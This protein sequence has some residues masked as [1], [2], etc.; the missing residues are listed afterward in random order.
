MQE[1]LYRTF[2]E[3]ES[4][5]WW[6]VARREIILSL[7]R[8]WL[9]PRANILDIGCGTGAFL[10]AAR[11]HFQV[12]GLDISPQA[13]A[14]C[15]ER[16]LAGVFEG[17]ASDLSGVAGQTFDG[18]LMLDVIEH[19]EDDFS[20][21]RN[22]RAMLA[23][24]GRI[25]ITVPAFM[26]FWSAHDEINQHKR[27]YTAT[28]LRNLLRDTGFHLEKLSYFNSFLFPVAVAVR[29]WQW[30]WGITASEYDYR[31]GPVN[32]LLRTVFSSEKKWLRK[33]NFPAG[34][35]LLAVAGKTPPPAARP[36]S[37]GAPA[38]PG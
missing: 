6:M 13:V 17:S 36:D 34:V 12:H 9:K 33:R 22:A 4:H 16:G 27:R 38:T 31:A 11:P 19:L 37:A 8:T 3:V 24:D 25:I 21:L 29:T 1:H 7:A 20:A 26:F 15:R 14:Y 30:L 35:S 5:H 32:S 2:H 23:D 18:I 10:E 28:Q